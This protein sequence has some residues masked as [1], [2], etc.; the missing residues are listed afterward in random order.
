[1]AQVDSFGRSCVKLVNYASCGLSAE[2]KETN[3]H[4]PAVH[5]CHVQVLQYSTAA[6]SCAVSQYGILCSL[7]SRS[8][9]NFH[10]VHTLLCYCPE[11][12]CS[13][14]ATFLNMWN[15]FN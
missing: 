10:R 13:A 7:S 14:T 4:N 6:E 11:G 1:M 8:R 9:I 3:V 15:A 2:I 5:A 12:G